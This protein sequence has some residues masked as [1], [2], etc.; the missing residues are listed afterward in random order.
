MIHSRYKIAIATLIAFAFHT[1]GLAQEPPKLPPRIDGAVQV[2]EHTMAPLQFSR[3]AEVSATADQVWAYLSDTGNVAS[4]FDEIR[5]ISDADVGETRKVRL[6]GGGNVHETVVVNDG[7]SRNFAYSI[8]DKNPMGIGDHLAVLTV[9]PADERKGSVV[10]WNHYFTAEGS[11]ARSSMS[12]SLDGA[13]AA[14]TATFGGYASHGSNQGFDP[15]VVRQS[16]I[17]NA[18]QAAVWEVVAEG[19]ADAHVWSSSIA[20]ITIT[21]TNGDQVVGDQRA[22]FIP[23]FNGETRET[24]TQ[25]DEDAGLFAYSVDQGLPPFVTYGEAVWSL[26]AID[27]NTTQVTVEIT[28]K[29]APGV[30]PQAIAFFRGGMAQLVGVSVDEAKYFIE[31]GRAHPRKIAALNQAGSSGGN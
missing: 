6:N 2:D 28:A 30:P 1:N 5:S 3:S 22:C 18:S 19:F 26:T 14:L 25:Y 13:F 21:D 24:I 9:L 10:T 12:A 20:E 7:Q 11:D 16:R 27:R 17:V 31:R 23:A 15:V 29:T 4:L 8:A